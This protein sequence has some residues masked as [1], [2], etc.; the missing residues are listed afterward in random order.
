MRHKFAD[1]RVRGRRDH[2]EGEQHAFGADPSFPNYRDSERGFRRDH[3]LARLRRRDLFAFVETRHRKN[4]AAPREGLAECRL[5]VDGLCARVNML[6]A[7]ARVGFPMRHQ[8]PAHA[9]ASA[10]TGIV[11]GDDLG[12]AHRRDGFVLAGAE[13]QVGI[14]DGVF[15]DG[16][17]RDLSAH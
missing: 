10:R 2:C 6:A 16:R 12:E 9:H 7:H 8:T 1:Q 3:I 17:L 5:G 13:N 11:A 15:P 14:I 4:P